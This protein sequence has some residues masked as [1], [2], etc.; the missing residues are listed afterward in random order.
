MVPAK[1]RRHFNSAIK[2]VNKMKD[3]Q[4]SDTRMKPNPIW[5]YAALSSI[6]MSCA[7]TSGPADIKTM[8][9]PSASQNVN[10]ANETTEKSS[11]SVNQIGNQTSTLAT[12][13][14]T[15]T[16]DTNK[17]SVE[18][19]KAYADRCSPN[20][21]TPPPQGLDCSEINLRVKRLRRSDDHVND[22]LIT[23][24]RLGRQNTLDEGLN[25]LKNGR[26]VSSLN[27]QAIA[28][29]ILESAPTDPTELEGDIKIETGA[30]I[31]PSK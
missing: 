12:P 19:L 5:L 30:I 14:I 8:K 13:Q 20:A 18:Q 4:N 28:S 25:D 17:L 24:D 16:L 3:I 23:L 15:A 7:S 26:P 9:T 31:A 1:F 22:A 29:G 6:L 2:Q 27:V 10:Y 11:I 21:V